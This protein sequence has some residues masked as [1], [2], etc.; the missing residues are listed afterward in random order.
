MIALLFENQIIGEK[1]NNNSRL[2]SS[3][4]NLISG[5]TSKIVTLL[6]NFG[7][8]TIF[9]WQL[10][11]DYLSV[12]GLYSNILGMLSLAELGFGTA[13]VYSMYQPLAENNQR[14]LSALL[15]LYQKVYFVIGCVIYIIGLCLIPFLDY[16][17]KNPPDIPH[18]TFYYIL[19]LTNS[20]I[21]YWF[22][23]YK[24]SILIADQKQ[25]I[26]TNLNTALNITRSILQIVALMLFHSFTL[27]L[28]IQLASTIT[29][30]LL[31]A[32]IANKNYPALN[33]KYED[34]LSPKERKK[35]A[36]DVKSLAITRIGHIALNSTDN[37][38]I[39]A[40]IGISWIG[41]L[42]NYSLITDCIVGV[43]CLF[44]GAITASLGNYF[45]EKSP[46][47]GYLLFKRVEFVNSW[48]YGICSIALITLLNPF[49]TLWLGE[50]Y[51]LNEYIVVAVVINFFVQGY[52]NTLWTFRSALG[53]FSQGW[54]RPLIVAAINIGLSIWLGTCW[55]VFGVLI[56]TFISRAAVNIW[57]DP[58]IIHKYGFN[59]SVRP[60]FISYL[61][62]VMQILLILIVVL[63]IKRALLHNGVS[64]Y[65]FALL[66][67]LTA[68]I[69]L[70]A[71]WIF[72]HKKD[73]YQYC[74][75]LLYRIL[76]HK[77]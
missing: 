48:L 55:G 69:S 64:I 70:F 35:I 14:K 21:S 31:T 47:E 73:E 1:M 43:L 23:G 46:D 63:T 54:Y 68:L 29:E 30:N 71:F 39:S 18:L 17:I 4:K 52:M 12:N 22:Q 72:N 36:Q 7:L 10:G 16:L 9:I 38:I 49:I 42:S 67:I 75:S 44:T 11:N 45:A 3:F 33:T 76:P 41:I 53:L 65:N 8:R 50:E 56:S 19:F 20:A 59:R 6:L 26:S 25:Y 62:R 57:F 27:Y 58:L 5:M 32:R 28:L 51:L 34:K 37:I 24:R 66:A 74:K 77:S 13:M 61:S 15:K 60:F 40:I 2:Q